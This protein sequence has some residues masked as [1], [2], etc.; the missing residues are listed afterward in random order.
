M[1]SR[2]V[3]DANSAAAQLERAERTAARRLANAER[4]R[5]LQ[6]LHKV[7]QRVTHVLLGAGWAT[8]WGRV[9]AAQEAEAGQVSA[10]QT[11]Y[12]TLRRMEVRVDELFDARASHS[13]RS[14][15]QHSILE[16]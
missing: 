12:R 8:W 14:A 15:L 6:L 3:E 16:M 9:R 10:A 7:V 1:W 2:E 13:K 4:R 11:V 5:A